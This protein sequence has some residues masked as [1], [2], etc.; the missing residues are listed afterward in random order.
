MKTLKSS[1]AKSRLIDKKYYTKDTP[2][3]YEMF[4]CN[5]NSELLLTI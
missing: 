5:L 4:N 3:C 1:G 2:N